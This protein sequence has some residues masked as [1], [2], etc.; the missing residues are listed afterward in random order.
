[1]KKIAFLILLSAALFGISGCDQLRANLSNFIAPETADEALKDVKKQ[2]EAGETKQAFIKAKNYAEKPS[3][4][5][6]EFEWLLALMAAENKDTEAALKYL[7]LAMKSLQLSPAEVISD[8]AFGYMQ[9]DVRFLQVLTSQAQASTQS[10]T[11]PAS[12]SLGGGQTQ[13]R[14]DNSGTEV[15]AGDIVI[16]LPN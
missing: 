8:K 6:G 5:Q 4:L 10:P 12:Q 11:S 16:K 13:I 3:P 7:S 9:T 2:M 1:M 15:R 14:M